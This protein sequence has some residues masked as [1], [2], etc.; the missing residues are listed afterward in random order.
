MSAGR[1]FRVL[2][3]LMGVA[4]LAVFFAACG[5][6][7]E[8]ESESE[9][10][11][12]TKAEFIKQADAACTKENKELAA[13]LTAF[14]AS[15]KLKN[16]VPTQAQKEEIVRELNIPHLEG[17]IEM[18]RE[19]PPPDTEAEQVEAIIATTED[20]LAAM[21][22]DPL[23]SLSDPAERSIVRALKLSRAFGLTVCGTTY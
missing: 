14:L 2:A 11:A 15:H 6:D 5:S 12:L 13:E 4:A 10:S 17:R 19:L 9:S 1:R 21:K 20:G 22:E 23:V 8:S 16:G 7:D 18:L 3:V